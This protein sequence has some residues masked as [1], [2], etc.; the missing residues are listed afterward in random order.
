MNIKFHI[1][2]EWLL[3]VKKLNQNTKKKILQTLV[4]L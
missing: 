4:Q 1:T 3:V 2:I